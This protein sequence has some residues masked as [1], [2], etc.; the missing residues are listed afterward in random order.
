MVLGALVVDHGGHFGIQLI[1][2]GEMGLAIGAVALD[3]LNALPVY[4]DPLGKQLWKSVFSRLGK[5]A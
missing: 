3:L 5:A 4:A 1:H 2:L